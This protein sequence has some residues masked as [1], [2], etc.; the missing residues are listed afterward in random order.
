MDIEV[1]KFTTNC[2]NNMGGSS[3]VTLYIGHPFK[4][5]H[6]L[7][8]QNKWLSNRGISIPSN[9][10]E[11]F[12]KLMEI[13]EKNNLPFTELVD[14]VIKEVELGKSLRDDSKKATEISQTT[15]EELK[16]STQKI[17]ID[18][19]QGDKNNL[20]EDQKLKNSSS[21]ID[22]T[23]SD[24]IEDNKEVNPEFN[25]LNDKLPEVDNIESLDKNKAE[26][27]QV[28]DNQKSTS[29]FKKISNKN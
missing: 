1:K 10:M 11:S 25:K 27:N 26:E 7:A 18:D 8:F 17:N 21:A 28:D 9:V 16:E 24:K 29:L 2:E 5:T 23:K 22:E 6:P 20:I 12:A 13:S 15:K 14:Y 19:P 4:D 3:P